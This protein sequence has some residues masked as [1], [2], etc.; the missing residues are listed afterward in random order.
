[1]IQ[2]RSICRDQSLKLI[3]FFKLHIT[4]VKERLRKKVSGPKKD[5]WWD[6]SYLRKVMCLTSETVE[7]SALSLQGIDDI[8]GGDSLPLGMLGVGDGITNNVLKE[9]F[10]DTTGFFIDEAGDTFDTTSAGKTTDSR[11]GDTLDVITKYFT[12]TLSASFS[13]T[14]SSL[15]TSRHVD[16]MKAD[17][18]SNAR[19]TKP[20]II[21]TISKPE[22]ADVVVSIARDSYWPMKLQKNIRK[23]YARNW[24]RNSCCYWW[25]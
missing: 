21:Y 15:S 20:H 13:Q 8:H 24:Q 12:M 5:R 9:N 6:F 7:G 1:M 25:L 19:L 23:L 3:H 22:C 11:L 14:F 10:Q 17:E 4:Q 16:T 18:V 2:F